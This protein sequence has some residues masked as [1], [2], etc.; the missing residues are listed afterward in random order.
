MNGP[1]KEVLYYLEALWE[2]YTYLNEE[3]AFDENYFMNMYRI[4][5]QFNDGIR[6][7]IAQIV[8]KEGGPTA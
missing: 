4:V 5:S 8:I 6:T 2:G 7:P 1:S 3:Q